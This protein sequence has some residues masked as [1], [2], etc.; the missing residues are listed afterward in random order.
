MHA[1]TLIHN[2]FIQGPCYEISPLIF[3]FW[4]MLFL[5][6]S[7]EHTQRLV[8]EDTLQF[9]FYFHIDFFHTPAVQSQLTTE[10]KLT[11]LTDIIEIIWAA[12]IGVPLWISLVIA[13]SI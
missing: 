4:I 5:P 3:F 13:L 9:L 10:E 8:G 6:F 11:S 1:C 7:T 2:G 12:R